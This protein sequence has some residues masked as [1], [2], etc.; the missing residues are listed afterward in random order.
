MNKFLVFS[1]F[2]VSFGFSINDSYS[3]SVSDYD[4]STPDPLN[5]KEINREM[6]E[7]NLTNEEKAESRRSRT[8]SLLEFNEL[9][10]I[11]SDKDTSVSSKS[12]S[13]LNNNDADNESLINYY[14]KYKEGSSLNT[15]DLLNQD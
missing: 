3:S 9:Q 14:Y 13:K 8:S 5:G 6:Y 2:L 11:S 4:S 15:K 1:A 10:G 12:A 7:R